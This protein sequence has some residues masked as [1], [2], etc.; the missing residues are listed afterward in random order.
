MK[1]GDK[2]SPA[3]REALSQ[4]VRTSMSDPEV[5]KRISERTKDGMMAA[6]GMLPELSALRRAWRDAR[7]T[8]RK[9]FLSELMADLVEAGDVGSA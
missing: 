4:K 2:H 3:A 8:V 1:P 9:R 5:R 7:P 6:A